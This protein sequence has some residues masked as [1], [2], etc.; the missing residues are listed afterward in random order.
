MGNPL[1]VTEAGN[2]ITNEHINNTRG[3]ILRTKEGKLNT[4][5]REPGTP[6]PGH[7]FTFFQ[8]LLNFADRTTGTSEISQGRRQ[9]SDPISEPGINALQE[10]SYQRIRIKERLH[11]TSLNQIGLKIINLMLQYYTFPRMVKIANTEN[12]VPDYVEIY[13]DDYENGKVLKKKDIKYNPDTKSYMQGE[14]TE[15]PIKK[16]IFDI[17]IIAGSNS[18]SI[19]EQN[20]KTIMELYKL[21]LVT[22]T[23]LVKAL[24]L[25][26]S[27]AIIKE[28]EVS[29]QPEA[30]Q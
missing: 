5:R 23:R 6:I 11:T 19:K 8:M 1:T 15:V 18:I 2:G 21:K 17:N 16:S 22:P 30:V 25:P 7:F 28:L 4:I 29:Q 3:A 9:T 24:E 20:K 14:Y 13:F 27:D 26:E 10:S 12:G